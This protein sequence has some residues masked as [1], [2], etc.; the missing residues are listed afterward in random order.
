V[1][2]FVSDQIVDVLRRAGCRYL[3]IVPGSSFRGL[4]DSLVNYG[5]NRDP[6]VI[7]CTSES[8]AVA[9]A[10]AYAKATGTV[11]YTV[12]HD[13]VGLMQATM[14]IYN[15]WCDRTPLVILGGGG[16]ADP[17]RR[18][19]MEWFHTANV[20]SSLV[21]DYVKW[22]D[23]PL[24]ARATVDAIA[25]GHRLAATDPQG[26]VYITI[27]ADLQEQAADDIPLPPPDAFAGRVP[28][29]ARDEDI[30][31]ASRLLLEA[32]MPVIVAGRV[33]LLAESTPL[34][35]KLADLLS[36]GIRDER[37]LNAV[38]T[39]HPLQL[40]GDRDA[41]A[42]ADVL[43]C[44][45]VHDMNWL[46]D[47]IG[48]R[49]G[50]TVIDLSHNDLALRSWTY[51]GHGTLDRTVR[52][53]AQALHGLRQLVARV[54]LLLT[55][56][57]DTSRSS[58]LSSR[59]QLLERRA[60]TRRKQLIDAQAGIPRT[61]PIDVALVVEELAGVVAEEPWL[62]T[63][64]N[65]RSWPEGVWRFEE[66]GQFLGGS[67]GGGVGY[68]PGALLGGALAARDRGQLAVA[69]IGDG[70]LMYAPGFLWSA[71]HHR[72]PML[73]VV[74]NNRSYYNDEQHQQAVAR[75]RNRPIDNAHVGIRLE[76][77]TIDLAA[78]AEGHG[79]IGIGPVT[80]HGDLRRALDEGRKHAKAGGVVLV[81]VHTG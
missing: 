25:L 34:L 77:P 69:I 55:H 20:Q 4:H 9:S 66:G 30:D 60:R 11:G 16:P 18:R 31:R 27:D 67:G 71:V 8:V 74:N 46:A 63:L 36:A 76:H 57:S 12:V 35:T 56:G 78:V 61:A 41:L 19:P 65:T 29:A 10:H 75:S 32:G 5:G 7:L 2:E 73:T 79:A 17:A 39:D 37:N 51:A 14:S 13:L 24:T 80:H 33:G 58:S 70:D 26:P 54:E 28:S 62:L 6:E 53:P 21:R 3:P 45:D 72:V 1:A 47:Q 43:L 23:D 44:V 48:R 38:P 64:R 40:Y 22:S 42:E 68:G 81:D 59:R 52:L 15:A 49:A 50:V